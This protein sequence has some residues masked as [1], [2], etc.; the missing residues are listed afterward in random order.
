MDNSENYFQAFNRQIAESND[1]DKQ[2][3]W[4]ENIVKRL[5]R[6]AAIGFSVRESRKHAKEMSGYDSLG[7]DWFHESYPQFPVRMFA[8]KLPNI[9]KITL[10]DIYG[11]NRFVNL[12]WWK[13]YVDQASQAGVNIET[14]RAAL[15]FNLPGAKDA[16]LMV[17][18]NQPTQVDAPTHRSELV[19]DPDQRHNEPWPRTTFPIGNGDVVAVLEAFPSFMQTVGTFWADQ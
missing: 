12:S 4:Q 13:E 8:A 9:H 15:F 18:H 10:G 1:I 17:L 11:K 14:E 5:L 2:L 7:F 6:Y 3:R 19:A 16:F